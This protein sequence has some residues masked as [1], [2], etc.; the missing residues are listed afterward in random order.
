MDT[1]ARWLEAND[2]RLKAERWRCMVV[3]FRDKQ[4]I[5]ALNDLAADLNKQADELEAAIATDFDQIPNLPILSF[6]DSVPPNPGA[7]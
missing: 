2:L 7:F 5:D 1:F 4:A 6:T 3:L